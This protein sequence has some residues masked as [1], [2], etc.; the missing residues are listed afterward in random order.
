MAH[1]DSRLPYRSR[2]EHHY[3]HKPTKGED[4]KEQYPR[5]GSPGIL[6]QTD[7]VLRHGGRLYLDLWAQRHFIVSGIIILVK[8]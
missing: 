5:G 7:P 6:A 2:S 1:A 4:V 3:S 8:S